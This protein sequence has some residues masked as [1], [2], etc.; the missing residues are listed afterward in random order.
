MKKMMIIGCYPPPFGGQSVH[1]KELNNFLAREGYV[2]KVLNIGD[3]RKKKSKDYLTVRNPLDYVCKIIMYAARKY[4]FHLHT[5][6]HNAKSWILLILTSIITKLL[7]RNYYVTLHS[8]MCPAYVR[9]RG[10]V[11]RGIMKLALNMSSYI[12]AVNNDIS[13]ALVELG[14]SKNKIGVIEAF[15]LNEDFNATKLPSNLNSYIAAYSPL[16]TSIGFSSP[17]Y[18]LHL[19]PEVVRNLHGK[20]PHLGIIVIGATPPDDGKKN[21]HHDSIRWIGTQD[22]L[23]S[24]LIMSRSD[25]F[26]RPSMTDGDSISVR[27]ALAMNIPVVASNVG[28]RPEGV[29]TFER[30][31]IAE[32][33]SAIERALQS[34]SSAQPRRKYKYDDNLHKIMAC[35]QIESN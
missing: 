10:D 26:V 15:S 32:L 13:V 12:I 20:Y 31:N 34:T 17:E 23:T 1:V 9:S 30:G 24:L 18:G 35:Y 29:I 19:L 21:A 28:H 27:E 33:T 4:S 2:V 3:E 22:R 8:G 6:G 16:I 5:N 25:L 11:V 14:V 7:A